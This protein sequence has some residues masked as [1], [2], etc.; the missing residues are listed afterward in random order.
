MFSYA[1]VVEAL[2]GVIVEEAV[3]E[4]DHVLGGDVVQRGEPLVAGPGARAEQ[5]VQQVPGRDT[6]IQ[7]GSP[8]SVQLYLDWLRSGSAAQ[9]CS[10]LLCTS[11]TAARVAGPSAQLYTASAILATSTLIFSGKPSAVTWNPNLVGFRVYS[12]PGEEEVSGQWRTNVT[13]SRTQ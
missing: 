8:D 7:V 11:S 5:R 3:G 4:L 9:L 2:Q 13:F 12:R 6:G 1:A 10:P